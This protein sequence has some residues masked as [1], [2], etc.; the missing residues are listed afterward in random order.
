MARRTRLSIVPSG[1][2]GYSAATP[3]PDENAAHVLVID[4]NLTNRL[5]LKSYLAAQGFERIELACDGAEALDLIQRHRPDV[6]VTD[7]MMPNIDGYEFIR[8]L[9]AEPATAAI[10]VIVQTGLSG[11][12]DRARVLSAGASDL[13]IKPINPIE[14][15]G[16][17][18]LHI[19]RK[20]LIES[21]VEAQRRMDEEL[22]EARKMQVSLLP[23]EHELEA[24]TEAHPIDIAGF[25][26]AS[27]GL[28]GDIWGVF[29]WPGG[30]VGIYTCDFA[31]H[32]VR[33]AL[34]TFRLHAYLKS[35][36][37]AVEDP[38]TSLARLN[39][40]LCD[41]L[42]VGQFATMFLAVIDFTAERVSYA[43]AASPP[44][45]L[46]PRH[47]EPFGLLDGSGLPLG[48]TRDA[49]YETHSA[50]FGP[51][52]ALALYSDA[53][54]ETPLPPCS[55]FT[56][57]TY[58]DFLNSLAPDASAAVMRRATIGAL[59]FGSPEKPADDLTLVVVRHERSRAP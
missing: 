7:L 24:L 5:I 14:L 27:V 15:T 26:Q 50:W 6:I 29:A 43:A 51:G 30:R 46:R 35:S 11:A 49:T 36:S 41:V 16:R 3:S 9:R 8:R 52:A 57:E 33:A 48:I 34:N 13:I 21:L 38:A 56:P 58:R 23:Q 45:P 25:Y 42:P 53:L 1:T 55:V 17:V 22:I 19:E 37:A 10:P 2:L 31:G 18:R 44:V 59:F 39:A 12:D 40:L 47:G 32:G 4:D 54:V 20:R 28:G